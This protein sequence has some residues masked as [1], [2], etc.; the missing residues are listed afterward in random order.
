[1]KLAQIRTEY[2]QRL[3]KVAPGCPER[4]AMLD[5]YYCLIR[6]KEKSKAA[7]G[8]RKL[9]NSAK[10][11]YKHLYQEIITWLETPHSPKGERS[12]HEDR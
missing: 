4:T 2:N 8:V 6:N 9:M 1:M 10:E 7:V 11:E 12:N 5:I 3:A